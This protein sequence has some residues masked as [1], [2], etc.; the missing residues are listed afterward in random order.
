M[1]NSNL[2]EQPPHDEAEEL[3]PWY[4]TGQLDATDRARVERHL[5][6]CASCREQL[7]VER[8]LIDEF[9]AMTPE[10]ESGWVRLKAR[11][12]PPRPAPQVQAPKPGFLADLQALIARPAVAALA[13][14]QMAALAFG[15]WLVA[16]SQPAYHALGSAPE[17]AGAN[18]IVIFRSEA[19]VEDVR[20]ALKG[21][22][23]SIVSGPTAADA[24]LL[25]VE[26]KQRQ[27]AL[28]RLQGDDDVQMAEPIDGG[29]P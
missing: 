25:H 14:A 23:A 16:L 1:P 11:I 7:K 20:D 26:P 9:Q 8:R 17:P 22:G 15:G 18:V 5:Y 29:S 19:T 4:A 2:F 12:E 13:A 3:I 24:Y 6:A 27:T 28:A 10:V 21:A